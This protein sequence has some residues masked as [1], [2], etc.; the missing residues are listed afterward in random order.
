MPIGASQYKKKKINIDCLRM[1]KRVA[2]LLTRD[3]MFAEDYFFFT[4]IR[5]NLILILFT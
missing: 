1:G 2:D 5:S 3:V 4:L